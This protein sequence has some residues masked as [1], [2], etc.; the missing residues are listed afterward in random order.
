MK[1]LWRY[2]VADRAWAWMFILFAITLFSFGLNFLKSSTMVVIIGSIFAF[3]FI[4]SI[5]RFY[6]ADEIERTVNCDLQFLEAR[7]TKNQDVT[8]NLHPIG[9]LSALRYACQWYFPDITNQGYQLSTIDYGDGIYHVPL[10]CS[11]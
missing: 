6:R 1:K 8:I 7:D 4:L 11:G 9:S 2:G 10:V 3:L 5:F